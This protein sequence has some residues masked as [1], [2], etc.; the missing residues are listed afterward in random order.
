MPSFENQDNNK[1]DFR[2]MYYSPVKMKNPNSPVDP[3]ELS[4]GYWK[5]LLKIS[6][7]PKIENSPQDYV[8]YDHKNN[9]EVFI[10]HTKARILYSEILT[11]MENPDAYKSVGINS[12]STG[13]I[14]VCNG[15][16][17]GVPGFVLVI[18]K[19]DPN[20]TVVSSY[21]YQ[22]N[23]N[24]HYS[25][26]NFDENT[27]KYDKSFY[28]DIEIHEFLDVLK[29]FYENVGG[30]NAYSVLDAERFE[31][32]RVNTKIGLMMDKLGIP[33][34]EGKNGGGNNKSFFDLA[35]QGGQFAESA[36]DGVPNRTVQAG[37]LEELT[38]EMS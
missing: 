9:I 23:Q 24:Y 10:N 16:E 3:S 38:G 29:N 33:K 26:R 36:A 6:I 27:L 19:L 18:R 30:Y 2:P 15:K 25:I 5:G 34:Y 21:M 11:L 35:N 17:V 1:K 28:D 37:S 32:S 7:S 8:T 12:G 20:G 22:F 14:S 4:F 13:L 31:V